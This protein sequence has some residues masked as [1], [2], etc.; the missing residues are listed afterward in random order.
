MGI[1]RGEGPVPPRSETGF[2]IRKRVMT[3]RVNIMK[4]RRFPLPF[5]LIELLVLPTAALEEVDSSPYLYYT[6]RQ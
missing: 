6:E 4:L 1:G 5:A 3:E 2:R